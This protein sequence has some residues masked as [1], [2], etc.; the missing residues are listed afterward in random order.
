[1]EVG[2]RGRA[3]GKGSFM[4]QTSPK[5]E[6]PRGKERPEYQGEDQVEDYLAPLRF[7]KLHP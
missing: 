1:M 2:K 4:N 5:V 6:E 7:Q 3:F